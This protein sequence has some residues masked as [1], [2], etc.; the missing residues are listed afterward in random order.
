MFKKLKNIPQKLLGNEHLVKKLTDN[1]INK[2][3][4]NSLIIH[5]PQGIGK[6]TFSFF[7]IKNIYSE[8][9]SNN[10]KAHHINL[11]NNNTHP[12][13]K[14]L[15]KIFD[16]MFFELLDHREYLIS[17]VFNVCS[18]NF[19]PNFFASEFLRVFK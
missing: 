15:Q 5:G 6:S 1:Y 11:I 12:N 18:S 2:N 16:D 14:Y 10:I 13:I 9:T 3:L 17:N 4:P 7:T 8:I 19:L